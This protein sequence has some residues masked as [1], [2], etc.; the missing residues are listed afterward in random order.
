[1]PATRGAVPGSAAVGALAGGADE[2][3]SRNFGQWGQAKFSDLRDF[4]IRVSDTLATAYFTF[5]F[6]TPNGPSIPGAVQEA[7]HPGKYVEGI[8]ISPNRDAM[9]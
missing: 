9:Q 2:S 7:R 5:T 8:G 4:D 1:M 6:S 3:M